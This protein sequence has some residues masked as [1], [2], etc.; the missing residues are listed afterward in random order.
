M[1]MS[2]A[3]SPT[4]TTSSKE[5]PAFSIRS[6]KTSNLEPDTKGPVTSPVNLPSS[7]VKLLVYTLSIPSFSLIFSATI[8]KLPLMIA[9]STSSSFKRAIVSLAPSIKGSSSATF[10]ISSIE[11]PSRS[12]TLSLIEVSKSISPCIAF[13][14]ISAISSSTFANFPISSIA[15]PSII[16]LSKSNTTSLINNTTK[17]Y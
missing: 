10:S 2:F 16:T 11:I 9:T 6:F 3:P 13:S 7:T 5:I 12:W 1:E 17:L 14:V 8:S 15:S 4:A